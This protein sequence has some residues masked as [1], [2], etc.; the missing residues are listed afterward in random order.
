MRLAL[1]GFHAGFMLARVGL[2]LCRHTCGDGSE[3]D[4]MSTKRSREVGIQQFKVG[5]GDWG[6]DWR[7]DPRHRRMKTR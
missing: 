3:S 4:V 5:R 1:V 7:L 2:G 6:L